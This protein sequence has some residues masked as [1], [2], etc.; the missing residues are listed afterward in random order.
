MLKWISFFYWLPYFGL[1]IHAFERNSDLQS[2]IICSSTLNRTCKANTFCFYSQRLLSS[3]RYEYFGCDAELEQ[4][5]INYVIALKKTTYQ[6]FCLTTTVGG[7]KLCYCSFPYC[8]RNWII[9]SERRKFSNIEATLAITT[10]VVILFLWSTTGC[11]ISAMLSRSASSDQR[12]HSR[13][14]KMLSILR[15]KIAILANTFMKAIMAIVTFTFCCIPSS[16]ICEPTRSERAIIENLYLFQAGNSNVTSTI[17]LLML[18]SIPLIHLPLLM[19]F[20]ALA[21]AL[22]YA[23]SMFGICSFSMLV[24]ATEQCLRLNDRRCEKVVSDASIKTAT[25]ITSTSLRTATEPTVDVDECAE[26]IE[27]SPQPLVVGKICGGTLHLR[28][29]RSS[30]WVAARILVSSGGLQVFPHKF[31]LP[32]ARTAAVCF[33]YFLHCR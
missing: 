31:L 11:C 13:D 16:I 3:I 17:A 12:T 22:I 9:K 18:P 25:P 6:N 32:P 4:H 27:I 7:H 1:L 5:Q 24:S 29:K 23:Y 14:G 19:L 8:N 33:L 28:N 15:S 2:A 21:T 30:E 10:L 26:Q 20:V